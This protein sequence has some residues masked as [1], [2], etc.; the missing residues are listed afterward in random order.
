M[1]ASAGTATEGA[2]IAALHARHAGKAWAFFSHVRNSTGYAP[3]VRTADALAM[4]LYP[5][6]GLTLHGFEVKVSRADFL[7]E[8]DD[9]DKC[10]E[11]ARFCDHWWLAVSDRDFVR[12]GELPAAWGLLA[13]KGARLEVLKDA[14]VQTTQPL[15][16]AFIAAL[17]RKAAEGMVPQSAVD[18]LVRE[19]LDKHAEQ[20][21][22]SQKWET[23]RV[24]RELTALRA[25]VD[26]FEQQSGVSLHD[27]D[28]GNVGA[29]VRF[30]RDGGLDRAR[31][32]IPRLRDDLR[33]TLEFIERLDAQAP[34]ERMPERMPARDG[35]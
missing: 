22:L 24:T 15:S 2:V 6:R 32:A 28:M 3:V 31:E 9:P 18:S 20:R 29:H 23:E 16:R 10:D 34:A 35:E 12:S 7:R 11:M 5:S 30:I 14:P 1:K 21:A 27:W 8:L 19:G 13:M 33:R 4:S 26:V 17:L 25:K